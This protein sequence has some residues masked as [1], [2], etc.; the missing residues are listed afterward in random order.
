[1]NHPVIKVMRRV[2]LPYVLVASLWILLSDRLLNGLLPDSADI[3]LWSICKG[4]AFVLVTALLLYL[5]LRAELQARD[6]AEAAFHESEEQLRLA[7]RVANVGLWDW[8]LQN[9]TVWFSPEW[10]RQIGFEDQELPNRFEEWQNRIHPDDLDR[11][12]AAIKVYQGKTAP[13]FEIEFRLRHKDGSYR[14]ILAQA[15]LITNAQGQ[16]LRMMGSHLDITERKR[17]EAA[18]RQSEEQIRLIME[19]LDDLVSVLDLDG[20]RLYNSSSYQGILGNLDRLHGTHSFDQVHPEDRARVQ[21]SFQKTVQTGIGQRNEYRL[22]D[23]H[24]QIRYIESQSSVIRDAQGRVSQV[25][26]VSRDVTPHREAERARRESEQK[27]RELVMLANSIILRWSRDGRITFLNEFGQRFFGYTEAEIYGRPVVGTLVPVSG[28]N[29]RDLPSLMDQ[30][31]ANPAAFEQNLN[32]NMRR[33]GERVWIAWT[34]RVVLDE[35][36]QVAEILSIGVDITALRRVEE[37]LRA[38][39]ASLEAR[40]LARTAELAEA[41]EHAESADRLKSAFLAT[42]SHELRTPLN[43]I[44]GF[45]GI[46]L[47]GLAGPLNAEQ[48]KQLGM[49]RTSARHLLA[50]INDVLDISKIEAGQLEI[51]AEPFDL[52]ASLEKVAALVKPLADKRGLALRVILP[53]DMEPAVS[54]RLRVE[55]VLLNL[56]NNAIKFTEHGAVTLEARR[57]N[58]YT[59]PNQNQKTPP[60]AVCLRVTDTGIGIKPEDREKIFQPFRQIDSSLSRQYEGT[61]LG[62]A[63]CRRLANLMGGEITFQ[64]VWGEGSVFTFVFP[65]KYPGK[66]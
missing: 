47:Q 54:D 15:S 4:L 61:G 60:P 18:L 35:R 49:V 66:P 30:I 56:L 31:R 62:L 46:L 36:G 3:T 63:I 41:K 14:W 6:Q 53:P 8:N 26:L 43:S 44:L 23:Q 17:A 37:E 59:F 65:L 38:T 39:Q 16:P 25:V 22:L 10:K 48:A 55:Q 2:I 50:L 5:L 32:E 64:S 24:G 1:M 45:T 33:N 57:I 40:V 58:D 29:G 12:L 13:N 52:P 9:N 28:S 42:M 7:V 20:R 51:H 19:N 11:T 34:N 27:Y 21:Q